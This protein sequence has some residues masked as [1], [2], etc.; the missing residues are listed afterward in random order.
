[1]RLQR[2][3]KLPIVRSD[4]ADV[5]GIFSKFSE[6][7][8]SV[9]HCA[10]WGFTWAQ[11]GYSPRSR[12]GV[13]ADTLTAVND[14]VSGRRGS[15]EVFKFCGKNAHLLEKEDVPHLHA[16][17]T[18]AVGDALQYLAKQ[19]SSLRQGDTLQVVCISEGDNLEDDLQ[20]KYSAFSDAQRMFIRA[21]SD[22]GYHLT[23]IIVKK[24]PSVSPFV[25]SAGFVEGWDAAFST[26]EPSLSNVYFMTLSDKET[27]F[28][29][30]AKSL[31]TFALAT[32]IYFI[33]T[34][35]RDSYKL[36]PDGSH[37]TGYAHLLA[38]KEGTMQT[39]NRSQLSVYA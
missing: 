16:L 24:T 11:N 31:F 19:K 21:C 23:I 7:P 33:G 5:D 1:M 38:L 13:D 30:E 8:F 3:V 9:T 36:R 12:E 35:T 14:I 10:P 29:N 4:A 25:F 37:T 27:D 6:E 34:T 26:L 32:K 39:R 22:L 17:A 2:T 20:K 15:A 18:L 28:S